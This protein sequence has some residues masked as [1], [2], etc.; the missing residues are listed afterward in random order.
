MALDA[1]YSVLAGLLEPGQE[2]RICNLLEFLGFDL[3][4][5]AMLRETADGSLEIMQGLIEFQEHLGG[6][7]TITLL[8]DI[9]TGI[10]VHEIN[11]D[12]MREAL[13][14]LRDRNQG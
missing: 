12:K 14:W 9:G 11:A 6:E 10:E 8:D 2:E 3:W 5:S 13:Y 1:R 7:L 4:H